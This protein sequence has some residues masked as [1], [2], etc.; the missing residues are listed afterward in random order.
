MKPHLLGMKS[1]DLED[2]QR[3]NCYLQKVAQIM[4]KITKIYMIQ[5]LRPT[6]WILLYLL[7]FLE[8]KVHQNKM[9]YLMGINI[10][11]RFAKR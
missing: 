1:K 7:K 11:L 8:K 10:R 4:I 2:E 9:I 5:M 3:G 6:G